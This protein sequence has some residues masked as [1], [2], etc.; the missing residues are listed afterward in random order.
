[1]AWAEKMLGLLFIKGH[2]AAH[3]RADLGEGDDALMSPGQTLCIEVKFFR[4]KANQENCIFSNVIKC[5]L[6]TLG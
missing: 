4:T 5:A 2:G 1:V 6:F 3:M